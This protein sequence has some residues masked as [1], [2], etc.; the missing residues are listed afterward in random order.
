MRYSLLFFL[1]LFNSIR[2]EGFLAGTLVR[3][4]EGYI[5][6]EEIQEGDNIISCDSNFIFQLHRVK[7]VIKRH[8]KQLIKITCGD[9]TLIVAPDQKFYS[10]TNE[11][12]EASKL[13]DEQGL[14]CSYGLIAID[15]IEVIN[16]PIDV[17]SLSP[18]DSGYF[19]ISK[20]NILV[21]NYTNDP[22][23]EVIG[24][25]TN[26]LL[27][28]SF[29]SIADYY[30]EKVAEKTVEMIGLTPIPLPPYARPGFDSRQWILQKLLFGGFKLLKFAWQ[31]R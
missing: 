7:F 31:H 11:W 26:Q 5:K 18:E 9:E 1:L 12:I 20:Y 10:S 17:Y 29:K 2:P 6:I 3:T 16:E 4:E 27:E 21:Y 8:V 13:I 15:S 28:S 24:E 25:E 14:M 30:V 23:K 22:I 19:Y